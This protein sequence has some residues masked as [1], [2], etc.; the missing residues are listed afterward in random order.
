[1]KFTDVLERY[2]ISPLK[3]DDD[4]VLNEKDYL[5]LFQILLKYILVKNCMGEKIDTTINESLIKKMESAFKRALIPFSDFELLDILM[6]Q[7]TEVIK[8]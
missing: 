4:T 1:M 5:N 2:H 8:V 3:Y 7:K 6:E